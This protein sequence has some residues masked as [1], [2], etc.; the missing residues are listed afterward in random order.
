MKYF[1]IQLKW[2]KSAEGAIKQ[3]KSRN[4]PKA[5]SQFGGTI[6]LVGINYDEKTKAHTCKIEKIKVSSGFGI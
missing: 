6:L 1:F 2:D 4:Y 5:L 3:I